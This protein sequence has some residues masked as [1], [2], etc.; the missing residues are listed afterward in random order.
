EIGAIRLIE[1]RDVTLADNVFEDVGGIVLTVNHTTTRDIVVQGNTILRSRSTAM[2]FGCHDGEWCRLS[3]L[4]VERNY[5]HGVRAARGS[6]ATAIQY[7]LNP[8]PVTRH[9]VIA[10]T[11]G[12]GIMVYG[13][14][15]SAQ[16]SL[17]E[18]NFVTG[19]RRSSA[20]VVGGGP[21]VVRN[22]I[23]TSSAE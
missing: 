8:T 14:R 7:T 9:N 15:D 4:V 11:K 22:N 3:R 17:I 21:V 16:A 12:P 5:I 13:A 20:I 2:Y 19:S 6:T 10:D 18:A 1:G 23:A